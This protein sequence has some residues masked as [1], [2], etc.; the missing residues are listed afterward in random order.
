MSIEIPN[1]TK[2]VIRQQIVTSL[3]KPINMFAHIADKTTVSLTPE[4]IKDYFVVGDLDF[5]RRYCN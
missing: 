5:K 1:T 4:K 3:A 2:F